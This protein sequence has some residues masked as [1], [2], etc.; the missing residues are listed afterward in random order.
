MTNDLFPKGFN[1]QFIYYISNDD[2]CNAAAM[3]V[4]SHMDVCT[5]FGEF[6]KEPSSRQLKS[7]AIR[8]DRQ[9]LAIGDY[10]R[11]YFM[12]I[13]VLVTDRLMGVCSI[14]GVFNGALYSISHIGLSNVPNLRT[15][16]SI[17]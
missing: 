14:V 9:C 5:Y 16:G 2:F 12:I 6:V 17:Q 10:S 7:F 1:V 15:V 8:K 13:E 4:P 3:R 11:L